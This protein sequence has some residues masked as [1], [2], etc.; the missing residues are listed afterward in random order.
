M[1][2]PEHRLGLAQVQAQ[3]V[4]IQSNS[5]KIQDLLNIYLSANEIRTPSYGLVWFLLFSLPQQLMWS[6]LPRWFMIE[7]ASHH[8]SPEQQRNLMFPIIKREGSSSSSSLGHLTRMSSTNTVYWITW[9]LSTLLSLEGSGENPLTVSAH[10]T[11]SK[12]QHAD[13]GLFVRLT[14]RNNVAGGNED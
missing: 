6:L 9:A 12:K 2:L 4:Q 3:T 13:L 5:T 14:S 11:Q 8:R 1:S 7:P 10:N